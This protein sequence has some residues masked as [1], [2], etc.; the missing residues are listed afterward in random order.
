MAVDG[1][2]SL[3]GETDYQTVA[4]KR[5]VRAARVS[6]CWVLALAVATVS[7]RD[8]GDNGGGERKKLA[9]LSLRTVN[10]GADG[11]RAGIPASRQSRV[12]ANNKTAWAQ[13]RQLNCIL[14]V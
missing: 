12:N 10:L 7:G 3:V 2:S 9:R 5:W 13:S 4:Y 6:V 1:G 8:D 14:Y 11:A